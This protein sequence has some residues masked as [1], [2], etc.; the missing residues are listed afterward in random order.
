MSIYGSSDPGNFDNSK[1]VAYGDRS[2]RE[3]C[4]DL[5][6]LKIKP[7]QS[8]SS[9]TGFEMTANTQNHELTYK[10]TTCLNEQT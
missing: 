10:L 4:D 1:N 9:Q 7:K 3:Q 5:C 6:I 2:T 8:K